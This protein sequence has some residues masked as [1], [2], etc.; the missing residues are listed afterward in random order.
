MKMPARPPGRTGWPWDDTPRSVATEGALWPRITVVTPSYNQ[1]AYLEATLRSVILQDYPN[2]EHLVLDGGSTDDSVE[3]VRR[4]EPWLTYWHS[5][6]DGGQAEAIATG[7]EMATGEIFC[8]LNSDDIFLPGSLRT[9]GKLFRKHRSTD[10][11]YGNR[12]VI[13]ADG[14]VIGRHIWPWHLTRAHWA[15]GQPM[16]QECC[17]WRRELYEKAGGIDRS[18]F[19]I[20]DYD[21]FFR[22]WRKGRFRKTSE[23]LGCIRVHEEAKNSRHRDVWERELAA[24]RIQYGLK[25]PGYFGIRMLNRWDRLQLA[26]EK[27]IA[28][29]TRSSRQA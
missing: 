6:K 9:V 26:L 1:G 28:R 25:L 19:F 3:I 15:I 20:L 18:K 7:F 4:Y 8:W 16:A 24:A 12:L 23:Y 10:F 2:L 17:F 29:P 11:V 21:L 5:R 14:G 13:D 22:M 27:T